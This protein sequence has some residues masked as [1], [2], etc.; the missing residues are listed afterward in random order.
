VSSQNSTKAGMESAL[1]KLRSKLA[2]RGQEVSLE[3]RDNL[4][5]LTTTTQALLTSK[6]SKKA[7]KDLKLT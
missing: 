6:N 2:S 1:N 4:R 3:C 7:I 5:S